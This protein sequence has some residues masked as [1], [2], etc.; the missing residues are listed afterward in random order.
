MEAKRLTY[1]EADLFQYYLEELQQVTKAVVYERTADAVICYQ[2]ERSALLKKIAAYRCKDVKVPDG[3]LEHSGRELNAQYQEK[4]VHKVLFHY[5]RKLFLPAP[6]TAAYTS[7]C[8][9]RYIWKG[10]K[11]LAKGKIE[12]PVLDGT[13]IGVS[14]LRGD[15]TTACSI[16]FLRGIGELLEEWTHKK[17]VGDLARTM[18]LNVEKVWL[19]EASGQEV[20]VSA[21]KVIENDNIVVHMGNLV[22]FDGTVA[23]GEAMINQASLTGESAPVRKTAGNTVFAGTVVE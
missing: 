11:A 23:D 7:L 13:S 22:P 19:K 15:T 3:I 20:L 18:S 16:M 12:V 5:G 9:V 4:L 14:V 17:S 6:I 8:A 10:I 21:A 1:K 2:G